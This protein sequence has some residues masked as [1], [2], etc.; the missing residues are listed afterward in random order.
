MRFA[1]L[2]AWSVFRDMVVCAVLALVAI[3][4]MLTLGGAM[5]EAVRQ[6]L[7]PLRVVELTPYLLPPMMPYTLPACVLFSCTIVLGSMSASNEI[8]ALKSVG[9]HPFHVVWPAILLSLIATCVSVYLTDRYIPTC[10]QEVRRLIFGDLGGNLHA[11]LKQKGSLV[12]EGLPYEIHVRALRGDRLV[13]PIFKHKDPEGKTLVAQ[14]S[15]ATLE[16]LPASATEERGPVVLLR[17]IDGV[18][19]TSEGATLRFH[20][21]TERMPL[22]KTGQPKEVRLE[23][24]T[25]KGLRE[26]QLQ[27][28]AESRQLN[29]DLAEAGCRA[30]ECGD[31][32][33]LLAPMRGN[34]F[35]H[36][37]AERRGRE[38]AAEL[39]R[40]LSQSFAS[41]PFV[42]LGGPLSILASR[43]DF[44]RIFFLCF[45]PVVTIYYPAM[46]GLYNVA[47]EG[48]E[49]WAFLL[50]V[51]TL[52]MILMSIPFFRRVFR[53]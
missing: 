3:S 32:S 36:A 21:R 14:A 2:I 6:G 25:Y 43:K 19:I 37:R 50:W 20:D 26:R 40:R 16:I 5:V 8:G 27:C 38:A 23:T 34:Q 45:L 33:H 41:I 48:A 17:M 52:A 44:L 47:K 7:D 30:L 18:A 4:A 35:H 1:S 12:E 51:P 53:Y 31:P 24:L 22:P 10:Q 49:H 15:E 28:R 9:I 29:V 46:I 42:L 13:A 11:F 39:H